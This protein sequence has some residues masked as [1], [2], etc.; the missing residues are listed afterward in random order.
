MTTVGFFGTPHATRAVSIPS[1]VVKSVFRFT[2][3]ELNK[4]L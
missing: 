1:Q 3:H 4:V 2:S